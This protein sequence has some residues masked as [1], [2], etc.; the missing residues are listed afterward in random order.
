MIGNQEKST[1]IQKHNDCPH[2]LSRGGYD[3]LE[4]KLLD[5]KIKK[6]QDKA[7]L[8]ENMP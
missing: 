8:T 7:M 6:R 1:G 4:N 5:E 2:L 3:L